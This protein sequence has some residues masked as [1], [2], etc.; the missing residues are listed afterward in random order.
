MAD[1]TGTLRAR[2]SDASDLARR[3]SYRLDEMG[4]NAR[5]IKVTVSLTDDLSDA[6]VGLTIIGSAP[7][8]A[9]ALGTVAHIE[10]CGDAGYVKVY[11]V[12]TGYSGVPFT[13]FG[14]R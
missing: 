3:A 7:T 4:D 2:L 14:T 8:L 10:T 5:M 13:V 6:T 9:R 11:A 1:T 12:T